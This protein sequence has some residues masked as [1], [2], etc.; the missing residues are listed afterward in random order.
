CAI[1]LGRHQHRVFNC[2]ATKTWDQAFD[3][4]AT[5]VDKNLVLIDNGRTLCCDWQR[6]DGCNSRLHDSCHLCSGCG[7][8]THGAQ[9]CPR[10]E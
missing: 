7:Q 9:N 5:R 2:D 10:A 3:T 8:S 6:L 4:I 1:C